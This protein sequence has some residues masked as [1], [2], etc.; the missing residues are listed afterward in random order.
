MSKLRN[1]FCLSQEKNK[2][3][4]GRETEED[5]RPK[6]TSLSLFKRVRWTY[7]EME[8]GRLQEPR[9]VHATT[10]LARRKYTHTLQVH[11]HAASTQ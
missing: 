5:K 1:S 6:N 11:T 8:R 10:V 9:R 3:C 7:R 2:E 4:T